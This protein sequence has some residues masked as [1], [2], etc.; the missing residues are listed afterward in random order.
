[1]HID[2]GDV[3]TPTDRRSRP[4]R[5]LQGTLAQ[6]AL[7]NRRALFDRRADQ[8]VLG[9]LCDSR[10]KLPRH[11]HRHPTPFAIT[12]LSLDTVRR[13]ELEGVTLDKRLTYRPTTTPPPC[14]RLTIT[15]NSRELRERSKGQVVDNKKGATDNKLF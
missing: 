2:V 1:M 10:R 7:D 11:G 4:S 14:S 6:I 9:H 12:H 13:G 8:G 15:H 5:T 3:L